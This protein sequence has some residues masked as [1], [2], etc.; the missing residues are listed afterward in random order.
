MTSNRLA[1]DQKRTE[2]ESHR[3]NATILI[4]LGNGLKGRVGS[5]SR[6]GLHIFQRRIFNCNIVPL[7]PPQIE[8]Q[9]YQSLWMIGF[10]QVPKIGQRNRVWNRDGVRE[11]LPGLI[12]LD[13]EL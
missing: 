8:V 1:R 6:I 12:Q 2:E 7:T 13:S 11:I 9:I 3:F 4:G 10:L 5:P